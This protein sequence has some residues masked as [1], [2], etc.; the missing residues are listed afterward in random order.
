MAQDLPD[1]GRAEEV[2][3]AEPQAPGAPGAMVRAT[4]WALVVGAALLAGFSVSRAAGMF[5]G[6]A[7][8]AAAP[9]D[10]RYICPMHPQ[11]T[12]AQPG[13]CPA[14][15]MRLERRAQAGA[16]A[17]AAAAEPGATVE[18]R[19]KRLTRSIR[20]PATIAFA[21]GRLVSVSARAQGWIDALPAAEVGRRVERG[22]LLATIDSPEL[23]R[24]QQKFL[25]AV[26]WSRAGSPNIQPSHDGDSSGD[27]VAEA[28]LQLRLAGIGD[29]EATAIAEA[30]EPRRTISLRAPAAG[31]LVRRAAERGAFV[32][33]GQEL[34]AIGDLSVVWA[35]ADVAESEIG[36][37]RVGERAVVEP[38]SGQPVEGAITFVYPTV[39]EKSRT[40]RVRVELANAD[41]ALRP[42]AAA[43]VQLS[44]P[45]VEVPVVP[46]AAVVDTGRG[47]AVFVA[48]EGGH[49][50]R[51]VVV[52]AR[53]G[54]EI[55]IVSGVRAGERVVGEGAFL[56]EAE[57]R[58][59]AARPDR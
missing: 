32:A 57:S 16:A 54:Q 59:R 31:V 47:P 23:F 14:C 28:R 44:G 46:A 22:Q 39:D 53:S 27:L 34:F 56:L 7:A 5:D 42:G 10:E 33:V 58:L 13:D 11:V 21:D 4:R 17:P 51:P 30:G 3:V 35:L 45:A 50:A 18:V 49:E 52:G 9:A 25:N 6:G 36:R 26:R 1:D 12:S 37:V 2:E 8:S 20:A 55:E 48:A 29:A 19:R 24:L 40:V 41:G 15:G 38:A 43:I